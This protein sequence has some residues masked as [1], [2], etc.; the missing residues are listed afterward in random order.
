[1]KIGVISDTHRN[2]ELLDNAA[3][4]LI[5]DK[6]IGA[7]YHLGDDFGDVLDLA[8]S[9]IE[10]VQVPGIYHPDYHSGKLPK[11]VTESILGVRITLVHALE[12]DLSDD[13]KYAS[14]I[15]LHGHT[16]KWEITLDD[17]LVYVNPGHMKSMMDKH[18]EPTF[19]LL[20]VQDH[21][22]KITIYNTNYEKVEQVHLM[23]SESGLFRD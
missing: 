3:D 21:S 12:K 7:L 20:D 6:H 16:H 2:R 23:R 19:A 14:D 17:G 9:G 11:V 15:I 22:V 5:R 4:W 1:M 18:R 10:I 13:D 8:D